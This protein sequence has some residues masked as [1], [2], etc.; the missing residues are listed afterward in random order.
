M[1]QFLDD[2]YRYE[3]LQNPDKVRSKT[4]A[5]RDGLNCVSLAHLALKE[6][7]D[8]DLPPD[9]GCAELYLDADHFKP[10][11]SMSTA[12]KG[13]L[14]WFGTENAVIEPGAFI[15]RYSATGELQNWRQF[16]VKH[17]T[18]HTGVYKDGEPMLLHATKHEG[19]TALWQFSRF[20]EHRLYR[21]FFGITRLATLYEPPVYTAA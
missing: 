3:F 9:L 6:L 12:Q 19:S 18:V 2:P 8:Y 16:P 11:E 4:D 21:R 10:V 20:N 1:Q 5:Q 15:P 17:V 7:F 13:D 14:V